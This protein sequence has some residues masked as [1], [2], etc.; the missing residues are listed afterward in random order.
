LTFGN[1]ATSLIEPEDVGNTILSDHMH[2]ADWK[3][4]HAEARQLFN[5]P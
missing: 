1:N 2:K 5:R 3:V 4:S